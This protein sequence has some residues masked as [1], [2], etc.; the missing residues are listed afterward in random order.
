MR[1]CYSR[2]TTEPRDIPF[3]PRP[4]SDLRPTALPLHV[5][6]TAAASISFGVACELNER[7]KVKGRR[8]SAT[9]NIDLRFS[10]VSSV[11]AQ[12]SVIFSV[13]PSSLYSFVEKLSAGSPDIATSVHSIMYCERH[14]KQQHRQQC[15][16]P[17]SRS[18][19]CSFVNA[20]ALPAQGMS[21]NLSFS[22]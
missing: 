12:F 21:A 1:S 6:C 11:Q 18:N 14:S 20:P 19:S 8:P 2:P 9:Q 7:S 22:P 4:R 16:R 10:G 15:D 13:L 5:L 17:S 3:S